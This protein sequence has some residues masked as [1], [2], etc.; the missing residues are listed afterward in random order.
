MSHTLKAEDLFIKQVIQVALATDEGYFLNQNYPKTPTGMFWVG[1][2]L[3]EKTERTLHID[4]KPFIDLSKINLDYAM[5][6][7]ILA[8]PLD[9][10]EK[11]VSFQGSAWVLLKG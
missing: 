8:I 7:N 10:I 6:G 5:Q 2:I 3:F 11:I 9:N 4:V 1:G